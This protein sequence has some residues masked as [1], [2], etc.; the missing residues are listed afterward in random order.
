ME[1]KIIK[2]L[3]NYM[4]N[5]PIADYVIVALA[6]SLGASYI[7]SEGGTFS[8]ILAK[9]L[10]TSITIILWG[11]MAYTFMQSPFKLGKIIV[12]STIT[13]IAQVNLFMVLTMDMKNFAI[14]VE[15]VVVSF[16][17]SF[18]ITGILI[19]IQQNKGVHSGKPKAT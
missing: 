5:G 6:V 3:Q 12:A 16:F 11:M 13:F 18:L 17:L 8:N 14:S 7:V 19:E 15:I 9:T 2:I 10:I 1:N 4:K